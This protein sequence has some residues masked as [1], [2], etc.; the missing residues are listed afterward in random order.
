M[1]SSITRGLAKA[2]VLSVLAIATLSPS[3]LFASAGG[4]DFGAGNGGDAFAVDFQLKAKEVLDDLK[5]FSQT[6]VAGIDLAALVTGQPFFLK[7]EK[8]C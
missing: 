6:N 8:L 3:T 2:V 7:L 5:A 1:L 4:G